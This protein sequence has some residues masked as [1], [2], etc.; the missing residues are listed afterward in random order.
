MTFTHK[1]V[2]A[3]DKDE[4]WVQNKTNNALNPDSNDPVTA[5]TVTDAINK[6]T[7]YRDGAYLD[8]DESKNKMLNAAISRLIPI[9]T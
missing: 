3:N 1:I 2:H 9:S 6:V 4:I 5:K 7:V 8:D